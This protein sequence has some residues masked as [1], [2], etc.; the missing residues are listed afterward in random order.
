[1]TQI[2]VSMSP[3]ITALARRSLTCFFAI[4][5]LALSAVPIDRAA[6]QSLSSAVIPY[7]DV[8]WSDNINNGSSKD[9]VTGAYGIPTLVSPSLASRHG[10]GADLGVV[11]ANALVFFGLGNPIQ[12]S[13]FAFGQYVT[14]DGLNS[15]AGGVN[16]SYELDRSETSTTK[17]NS[18]LSFGHASAAAGH[19]T[20]YMLGL[21]QEY[22]LT[23]DTKLTWALERSS[24]DFEAAA[25]DGSVSKFEASLHQTFGDF[26]IGMTYEGRL[27]NMTSALYSGNDNSVSLELSY[28]QGRT[29]V[30]GEVG[31]GN[32]RDDGVP[33][34]MTAAQNTNEV[35]WTL[36]VGRNISVLGNGASVSAYVE[37]R[38]RSSNLDV[39]DMHSTKVG[40]KTQIAF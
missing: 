27:R 18:R 10:Y 2:P 35:N 23:E 34:G 5:T 7:A 19:V 39:F 28:R 16:V 13:P 33:T 38:D 3:L 9:T 4:A 1:M 32:T 15:A 36:G 14:D 11:W 21:E 37:H 20:T 26:G 12:V 40:L 25:R 30:F 22:K 17:L 31:G 6:A 29:R 24:Y 8:Y